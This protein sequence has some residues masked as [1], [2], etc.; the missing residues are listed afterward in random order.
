LEAA[1]EVSERATDKEHILQR[2]I[3]CGII[4]V[5]RA[6]AAEPAA[7][8]VDAV[9]AGG[10][11]AIEVT[12]TVPG[13]LG[14]IERLAKTLPSDVILGAGTVLSPELARQAVS[15]G[16]Q[17]IVAPGVDVRVIEAAHWYGKPAIPGAL[18]PTEVITALQAGALAVKLF[19]I[20]VMGPGYI[21][22]LHGPLPG[23]KFVPTGGIDLSNAADYLKAGAAALGVGSSLIDRKLV[24]EGNWKELTLRAEKFVEVVRQARKEIS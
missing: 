4:A 11:T 15:A 9:L 13:A 18:T 14:I 23:T 3:D 20:N 5:V 10:V 12:F 2:I 1:V 7:S 8:A 17:F 16:A 21:R 6:E 24:K 19:P 22:D